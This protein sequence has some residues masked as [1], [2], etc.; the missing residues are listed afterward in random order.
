MSTDSTE[1]IDLVNSRVKAMKLFDAVL[2]H[3]P[4]SPPGDGFTWAC[5]VRSWRPVPSLS[6]LASTGTILTLSGRIFC[7]FIREPQDDIDRDLFERVDA[8]IR[9]SSTDLSF[10]IANE[11]VWTDLLGQDSEGLYAESGYINMDGVIFRVA[12]LIIPVVLADQWAQARSD[13]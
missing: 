9:E 4:K 7:R 13:A 8:V 10:G 11:S 5:W 12:D 1:I 2:D 3:E 6:G